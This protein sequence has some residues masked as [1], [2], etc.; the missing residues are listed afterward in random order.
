MEFLF[1]DATPRAQRSGKDK[2]DLQNQ[3]R[4]KS[5]VSRHVRSRPL[6]WRRSTLLK[7]SNHVPLGWRKTPEEVDDSSG[8]APR[9]I[10]PAPGQA[11]DQL[12]QKLHYTS[13]YP[14]ERH[15]G[16]RTDPFSCLP[17]PSNDFTMQVLDRCKAHGHGI[18]RFNELTC[19]DRCPGTL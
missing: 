11:N 18:L 9:K 5:H 1:V 12:V 6:P 3:R 15:D 13:S 14:L 19:P 7:T 8:A 10:L 16:L 2:T 4:I 17:V